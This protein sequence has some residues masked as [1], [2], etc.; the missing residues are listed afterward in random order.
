[1]ALNKKVEI[2]KHL[3]TLNKNDKNWTKEL[4]LV[5]WNG[6]EPKYDIREWDPTHE[7]MGRGTTLTVD[8]IK[9]LKETLWNADL[10]IKDNE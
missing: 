5:S 4:N 10:D 6:N 9:A 1:M 2:I 7:R 3:A 8:E